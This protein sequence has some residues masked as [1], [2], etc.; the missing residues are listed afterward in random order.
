MRFEELDD[1][2]D[3]FVLVESIETQRGTPKPLYFAEN[4]EQF[5]TYLHKIIHVV[6]NEAHPEMGKWERE[7]FQRNCIMRGLTSCTNE[8]MI[9]ISD[10]DEIPR[11]EIVD[12]LSKKY[13]F[14][15][16]AIA[17]D[18]DIYFYQLNRQMKTTETWGGGRWTGTVIL[19]LN[20]LKKLSP[21]VF[22]TH[23][24]Y[25]LSIGFLAPY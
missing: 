17:L 7:N 1:H 12:L 14:A 5:Q 13:R 3:Y 23:K 20:L 6:V 9:M 18:M 19:S 8:D 15:K 22:R 2:V 21:Q 11:P 16:R 10:V 24:E 4:R 25:L